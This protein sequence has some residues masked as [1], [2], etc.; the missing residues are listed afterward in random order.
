MMCGQA[1]FP[2]LPWMA[3]VIRAWEVVSG[4]QAFFVPVAWACATDRSFGIRGG[5]MLMNFVKMIRKKQ[6]ERKCGHTMPVSTG[7]GVHAVYGRKE[8][9]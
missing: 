4:I 9:S 2:F 1:Q 7:N 6:S 3:F 8:E 5:G